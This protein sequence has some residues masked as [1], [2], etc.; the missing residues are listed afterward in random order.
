ML[1]IDAA[2]QLGVTQFRVM[3]V[4]II[5]GNEKLNMAFTAAIFNHLPGLAASAGE[6][7][8]NPALAHPSAVVKDGGRS[9]RLV[10]TGCALF[11]NIMEK[12]TGKHWVV[13]KI[14][15]ATEPQVYLGL[16][17]PTCDKNGVPGKANGTVGLEGTGDVYAN[18]ATIGNA[19]VTFA[20]GDLLKVEYD[21]D[22]QVRSTRNAKPTR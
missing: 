14:V 22:L 12:N 13:L 16:M 2:T 19:G 4:D 11:G 15:E 8:F 9:V 20:K 18:G 7:V 17:P 21:S 10:E 3:P 1:V 5:K 6:G